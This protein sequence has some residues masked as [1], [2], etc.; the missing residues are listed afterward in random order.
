MSRTT[1]ETQPTTRETCPVPQVSGPIT[2]ASPDTER[3]VWRIEYAETIPNQAL[4]TKKNKKNKQ[5][6]NL[7]T[8][9]PENP[10]PDNSENVNKLKNQPLEHWKTSR[11][12]Y[13]RIHEISPA[14]PRPLAVARACPGPPLGF[15]TYFSDAPADHSPEVLAVAPSVDPSLALPEHGPCL[16]EST[17]IPLDDARLFYNQNRDS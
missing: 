4:E 6:N 10:R 13:D 17:T 1:Q 16:V 9:L 3:G 15:S 2:Q 7:G 8:H 5:A 14:S 11:K 12:N